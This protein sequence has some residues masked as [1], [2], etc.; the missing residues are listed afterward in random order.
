MVFEKLG[1]ITETV[2]I[3]FGSVVRVVLWAL[4]GAWE[5]ASPQRQSEGRFEELKGVFAGSDNGASTRPHAEHDQQ[6]HCT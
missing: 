5:S 2:G 4:E 1:I 3:H 6:Y